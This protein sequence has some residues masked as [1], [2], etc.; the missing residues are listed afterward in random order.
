LVIL[1]FVLYGLILFL[2]FFPLSTSQKIAVAPL[3]ALLGELAFWP[4]GVLLGR[5]V[6]ARYKAYLNPCNWFAKP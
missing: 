2:P 1:S 6:V 3:L 4:G 5:E